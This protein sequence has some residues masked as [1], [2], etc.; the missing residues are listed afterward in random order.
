MPRGRAHSPAWPPPARPGTVLAVALN[1][2]LDVTYE[3]ERLPSNGAVRVRSVRERPGGKGVNVA[4]VLAALAVDVTVSGLAGGHRGMRI[5]ELLAGAGLPERL[6]GVSGESRQTVVA[7]ADDGAFAE[8]DE[9]GMQVSSEEWEAYMAG[10]P[11][12]VETCSS[13]VIAG[14]VPGELPGEACGSL[15][16]AARAGGRPV[17][18]DTSGEALRAGIAACPEMVKIN[19]SE[20]SAFAEVALEDDD[21]VVRA[22]EQIRR[23]GVGTVVVT[24]GP[25]G[26][27]ALGDGWCDRLRQPRRGGSPVGAGD[28]FTAGLVALPEASS[29]AE[30]LAFAGALAASTVGIPGAGIVDLDLARRLLEEMEVVPI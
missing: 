7:I 2:A 4:S 15:I 18:L 24:L 13:V 25:E 20:L 12:L 19:R 22:A 27:I 29:R 8:F 6:V 10:W 3:V 28:A 26:A 23:V 9:P 16:A 1:A 17:V 11:E 21:A 14:S 5:R 30:R